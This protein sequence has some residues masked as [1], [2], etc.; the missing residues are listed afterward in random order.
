MIEAEQL[1]ARILDELDLSKEV[2]DEELTRIIYRVLREAE[3][4][5]YLLL[6]VKTGRRTFSMRKKGESSSRTNGFSLKRS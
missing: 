1:H 6:N 3:S 5:E 4:R 2:E